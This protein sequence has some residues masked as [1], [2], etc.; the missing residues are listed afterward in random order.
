MESIVIVGAGH[1]AGQ[2][3]SSLVM[4]GFDGKITLIGDEP[5]A[6][7]QRPPLS[8]KYLS[9]ELPEERLL[10]KPLAFYAEHNVDL[11]LNQRALSVDVKQQ[12][13]TLDTGARITWDKLVLATGSR[14]RKLDVPGADARRVHYLRNIRDV[15]GIRHAMKRSKR[16]AIVGG[17]YIGLEVAAIAKQNDFD[18]ALVEREPRL[19]RRAVSPELS[20]FYARVHGDAGVNVHLDTGVEA[21]E[22][23]EESLNLRLSNGSTLSADM[24]IVGVG[25]VPTTRLAED[26]E[27]E[28]DNGIVVDEFCQTSH[29]SILAIGDCTNHPNGIL[30]KRL[31]LESVPN[32]LAQAKCAAATLTGNPSAYNEVPWFWSDQYDLKLQIVGLNQGY[33]RTVIRGSMADKQFACFYLR[34][35]ALIAVDAVNSPREFM[36]S[37]PAVAAGARIPVDVLADASASLKDAASLWP[38]V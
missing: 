12:T 20:D 7:Y 1:A 9:G 37:K 10:L 34:G 33:D 6:P 17:G 24:A 11:R 36:F 25:V 32:A 18:V 30:G 26:L 4:A 8:K 5:S 13:V 35:G 16:I 3:V 38:G 31:R 27:L 14:V 15:D 21:F 29:P 23:T 2:L 22:R 19:L 28:C